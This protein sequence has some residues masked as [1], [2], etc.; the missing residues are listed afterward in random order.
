MRN[1]YSLTGKRAAVIL[2]S[3]YPSD[4]RP[5]RAAEAMIEA[6]LNVDLLCLSESELDAREETI[7]GVHVRRISMRRQRGSKV[8]Y[9]LQDGRFFFAA[10]W[11]LTSRGLRKKYD[12]VHVHNMPDFLIFSAL[13]PKLRGARLILDLHDPMPEL[14]VTIYDLKPGQWLVRM[15]LFLERR[16]I[17][18]SHTV[19]TPNIA[20]K[21]LFVSRSGCRD[22]K[23]QIVMNSPRE[24]VFN[25]DRFSAEPSTISQTDEF[26]IMHHGS[27]VHRH[28]IDLLVE[29]VALVRPKIAGI[30]LDLYGTKTTF[31]DAVLVRAHELNIEDIVHYHG[32]KTQQEIS[33]IIRECH[34]GVVPN[35]RSLFTEINFPTRLFEYL[36]MHRPVIAPSTQGI[37]DYFSDR[38][39]IFFR[40]DDVAD[41]AKQIIW[42]AEHPRETAACVREGIEVYRNHL[43]SQEKNRFVEMLTN[44]SANPKPASI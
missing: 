22:E 13:L 2:Y 5:N 37:R 23:I 34:L 7:G 44:L 42:V 3:T 20:F 1:H 31:L 39:M 35:R 17:R 28:G 10:F 36:S 43:W 19:L 29:A 9:L 18:F 14:M 38:Q 27:I 24:K 12:F 15:L 30:R 32:A 8:S 16:C 21:T 40:P 4:P 25:P 6:G 11:F 41:L 26:R 33:A